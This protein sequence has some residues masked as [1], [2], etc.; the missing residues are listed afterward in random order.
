MT[1]NEAYEL[2][3]KAVTSLEPAQHFLHLIRAKRLDHTV[4]HTVGILIAF[5]NDSILPFCIHSLLLLCI[6][7]YLTF[8]AD[9][10]PHLC[11]SFLDSN[12]TTKSVRQKRAKTN[13][14]LP[15]C[16]PYFCNS[17]LSQIT[18]EYSLGIIIV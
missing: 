14:D 15:P 13:T 18:Y 7:N 4:T 17:G 3:L 2:T 5:R 1:T 6:H 8:L 16:Y 11:F 12:N 9:W 10:L